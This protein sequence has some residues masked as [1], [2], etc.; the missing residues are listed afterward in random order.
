MM[1]KTTNIYSCWSTTVNYDLNGGSGDLSPADAK[2][3]G[4][5][6]LSDGTDIQGPQGEQLASW[7]TSKDGS[8]KSYLPGAVL[9]VADYTVLYAQW[10]SAPGP[11]PP[12]PPSPPSDGQG[13]DW[14]VIAAITA[15]ALTSI[16]AIIPI[17]KR[18]KDEEEETQ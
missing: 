1:G 2:I 9:D 13:F 16:W 17:A 3:R 4:K 5:V 12:T 11:T 18:R 7:N 10:G 8:G 15:A 14:I 6:T